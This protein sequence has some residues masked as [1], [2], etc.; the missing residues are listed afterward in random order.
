[1]GCIVYQ[2]LVISHFNQN[3][4]LCMMAQKGKFVTALGQVH[5]RYTRSTGMHVV[6]V[7]TRWLYV[8]A[9]L[10]HGGCIRFRFLFSYFFLLLFLLVSLCE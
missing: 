10:C 6:C 1:M 9:G 5:I 7:G 4:V 2:P 3:I 8:Y